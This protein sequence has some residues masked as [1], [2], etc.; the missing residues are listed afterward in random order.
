MKRGRD[1]VRVS[2]LGNSSLTRCAKTRIYWFL[3]LKQPA[4][5]SFRSGWI[6]SFRKSHLEPS[7]L[8]LLTWLEILASS[9]DLPIQ[10][11]HSSGEVGLLSAQAWV[12]LNPWTHTGTGGLP[13]EIGLQTG[14]QTGKNNRNMRPRG[15][16]HLCC[17]VPPDGS[18]F[19]HE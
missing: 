3:Y 6:G 12:P 13:K 15:P 4:G 10:A 5:V 2:L 17:Y 8:H 11:D 18:S 19:I 7:F 9:G 14:I 16:L 1:V